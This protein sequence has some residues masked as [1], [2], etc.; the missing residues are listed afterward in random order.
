MIKKFEPQTGAFFVQ[1]QSEN[2]TVI[3]KIDKLSKAIE[4]AI[5]EFIDKMVQIEKEEEFMKK[6]IKS[7]K[8]FNPLN[9]FKKLRFNVSD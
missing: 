8:D 9:L 6:C 1:R 7:Q 3:R 4:I 2:D 5:V